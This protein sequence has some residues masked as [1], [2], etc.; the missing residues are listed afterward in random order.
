MTRRDLDDLGSAKTCLGVPD[1]ASSNVWNSSGAEEG[2]IP[3]E[4]IAL[5]TTW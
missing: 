5:I 1:G 2:P 3:A 4:L